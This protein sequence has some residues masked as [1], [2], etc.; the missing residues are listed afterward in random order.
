MGFNHK[1]ILER[2]QNV[3]NYQF[4]RSNTQIEVKIQNVFVYFNV[5]VNICI[6]VRFVALVS[7]KVRGNSEVFENQRDV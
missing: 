5:V 1:E 7:T 2:D 6:P 4:L 3:V